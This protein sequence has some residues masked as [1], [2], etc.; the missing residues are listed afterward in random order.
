VSH[1]AAIAASD[2]GDKVRPNGI[3]A[4]GNLLA[5]AFPAAEAGRGAAGTRRRSEATHDACASNATWL[6]PALAS[7]QA[8]MASGN[9][10]VMHPQAAIQ[11]GQPAL[12]SDCFVVPITA[13]CRAWCDRSVS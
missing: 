10:K 11:H 7:L 1:A 2:D 3:R 5:V 13:P 12:W 4:L 9:P 6:V 8:G